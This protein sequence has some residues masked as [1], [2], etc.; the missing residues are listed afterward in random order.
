MKAKNIFSALIAAAVGF[1]CCMAQAPASE[2]ATRAEIAAI[3]VNKK[4]SNFKYWNKDSDS[5]KALT[6][7]VKEITDKNGKNFI[8]A[9]DRV[10]VFDMDGTFLCETAPYYLDHML[11]LERTLHDSGYKPSK[12]DREFAL[13]LEQWIKHKDSGENLGD[14][15]PHQSSVF[16][17]TTYP[18]YEAYVKNFIE[19][20]VEGLSPLKWGEAFYLPMVE[21]MKYLKAN[22]LKIYVVSGTERELV[23]LLVC[24]LLDIPAENIIGTDIKTVAAHQGDTDGLKYTYRADDCLVR[25]GF[26]IKNLQMNKV[27]AIVREIGRQPVLAF[28]NSSGDSAML[29]YA[30]NGN[31]YKSAA[32]FL[33]CDDTERELGNAAK[34]E[35]SKNLA[36]K[37]G[38]NAVS[39]KNDWKTIY[40]DNVTRTN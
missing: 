2:A 4:G 7:Y 10:A 29:N 17:G 11:F 39:M 23:R 19:K 14:S 8:P 16:V 40:G 35:K 21:V 33:L 32:F 6:N 36:D 37:N 28:G 12:D 27:S 1:G 38:W 34:A 26:V 20:P 22:D 24:D 9:E 31:K 30:T 18:D 25:G 5:Y 15:A 13:Y 3:S